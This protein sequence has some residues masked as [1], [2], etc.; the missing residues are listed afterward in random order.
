MLFSYMTAQTIMPSMFSLLGYSLAWVSA[1]NEGCDFI[2]HFQSHENIW[3]SE[4]AFENS[5]RELA[6]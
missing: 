3:S 6:R 1:E 4:R 5:S 2:L